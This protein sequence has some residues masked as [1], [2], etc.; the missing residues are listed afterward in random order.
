MPNESIERATTRAMPIATVKHRDAALVTV[1]TEN[2][3]GPESTGT[4][5]SDRTDCLSRSVIGAQRQIITMANVAFAAEQD[6]RDQEAWFT[7]RFCSGLCVRNIV[8]R[9]S[10]SRVSVRVQIPCESIQTQSVG[11]FRD[12]L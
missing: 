5:T 4:A 6:A 8:V 11:G 7:F 9:S 12:G 10:I 1:L 3:L 2:F